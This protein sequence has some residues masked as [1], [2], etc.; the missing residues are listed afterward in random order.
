MD[1]FLDEYAALDPI[2][3]TTLGIPGHDTR[4]PDLSPDGL[5]AV[6]ALR[7]RTLAALDAAKTADTTDQVTVAAARDQLEVAERIRDTGA[8]E[9][10]LNNIA[11]PVQTVR[12]VFDLMPTATEGDWAAIAAR[13]RQVPGA[14][15]G[16]VEALRF[17]ADRGHISPVRQV[18]AAIAQSRANAATDGF[19]AK[20]AHDASLGHAELPRSLHEELNRAARVA[21]EGY[22]ELATFLDTDLIARAPVQDAVGREQYALYAR[23]FLGTSIDLEET[24]AWGQREL[25]DITAQMRETAQQIKPGASVGEAMAYLNSDPAR[26]LSGA[27]ALR[28][29]MQHKSDEA[30]EALGDVH[31]DIPAPIRTL[32]CRIA[33][34]SGGIYY[35]GPSDDFSRPGRM[36]WSVPEGV[37][38]FSTWQELTTVYHEGVPGHHLQIAQTVYRRETLN[39]WRRLASWVSGHGEG[40]GL[41]AERLMADLG[42]LDDP[43]DLL[44][45][46]NSQAFRAVRVVIDIGVHCDFEAPPEVGGGAW[47]YDKAWRLLKRHSTKAESRLRYEL[48]RYLGLPG[49]APS[50]KLGER[51]WLQLRDDARAQEGADFD[52]KDFHRRA[53]DIGGVGL[54]V[55]RAA[56]LGHPSSDAG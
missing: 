25:S 40:W 50:Y 7:R 20:F 38:E 15:D 36:W 35:T 23:S 4:L 3:A 10:R 30:I 8:E 21:A 29:W 34:T 46:L 32:E 51:A 45:M 47:S 2:A 39:R 54:D 16:Y 6:S 14:I 27:D 18:V 56:V 22:E 41:Y 52:L 53:L 28:D 55:L 19:F 24:Y 12:E 5:A 17:A 11:S 48:D 1:A 37:T 13:L 44:G 31:F 26:R 9:A 49:Q 42:F 43:G 33:P